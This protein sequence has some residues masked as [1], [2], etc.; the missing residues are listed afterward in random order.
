MKLW[1]ISSKS[2]KLIQLDYG[3]A[4]RIIEQ[5]SL[6]FLSIFGEI[7]QIQPGNHVGAIFSNTVILFPNSTEA[8]MY[9]T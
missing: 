4:L 6:L 2:S 9:S 7:G 5:I 3:S 1:N 8:L